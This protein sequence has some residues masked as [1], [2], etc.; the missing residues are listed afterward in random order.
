MT[1]AV[2]TTTADAIRSRFSALIELGGD[3]GAPVATLY[4][5]DNRVEPDTGPWARVT[6]REGERVQADLGATTIRSRTVGVLFVELYDEIAIGTRA[7]TDLAG[8]VATAFQRVTASGVTYKTPTLRAGGS[9]GERVGKWWRLLVAIP[10]Y[11][12]DFDV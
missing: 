7:L 2:F 8:R 1:V 10:F 3:G 4:P 6:I 12:D 9:T 5:N 11:R